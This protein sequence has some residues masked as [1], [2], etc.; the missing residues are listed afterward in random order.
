MQ[1]VQLPMKLRTMRMAKARDGE[2]FGIFITNEK[3]GDQVTLDLRTL[4][5]EMI[6]NPSM[7]YQETS[8]RDGIA[9]LL[10]DGI[11]LDDLGNVTGYSMLK[12]HPGDA[13]S[14]TLPNDA[15]IVDARN[16]IHLFN[17]E[18]PG[19][20]RGAPEITPALPLYAQL[21]R[22]TLAVI[23]CAE[24]AALPAWVMQTRNQPDEMVAGDP[25]DTVETERGMGMTLPEGY[26]IGQIKAE[27]PTGTYAEFKHQILEEIA[28]C[29]C[30]PY[31]IAAGISAG[32]NYSSGRL[33]HKTYYRSLRVERSMIESVALEVIFARWWEEA[34][35]IP[36]YLPDAFYGQKEIPSHEWRWDGDEHVDPTKEAD[37]AETRVRM[38]LSCL[39][40][41]CT[42][43]GK[44]FA[45]IQKNNAEAM[46]L[47]LVEYRKRLADYYLPPA[48]NS[49]GMQQQRRI[50][51][52]QD[53][54]DATDG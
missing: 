33:D 16:I 39:Q 26:E 23:R 43:L 8:N 52:P 5:T 10:Y 3:N 25:F 22:Y 18:R 34:V 50:A 28:R 2:G 21:R 38:G 20:L 7:S 15:E 42:S 1:A 11:E 40:D 4:E 37:A 9:S 47:S 53:T 6:A 45:T 54:G 19:Q 35:L 13:I 44:D 49:L 12:Q 31:N 29:L 30:M 24:S 17:C 48:Q 41:E 46:G 14:A 32:Y 36:G 27:Q 51:A